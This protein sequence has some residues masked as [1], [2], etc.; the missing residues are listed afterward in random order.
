LERAAPTGRELWKSVET[1]V[2]ALNEKLQKAGLK[3][4]ELR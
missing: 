2:A 3:P 4:I 1:D